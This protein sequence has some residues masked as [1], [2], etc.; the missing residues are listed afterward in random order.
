MPSR[1]FKIST[2]YHNKGRRMKVS[3]NQKSGKEDNSVSRETLNDWQRKDAAKNAAKANH[4]EADAKEAR[5]QA[6]SQ[7][8]SEDS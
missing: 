3:N 5:K 4:R 6:E 7:S 2:E 8:R 1:H